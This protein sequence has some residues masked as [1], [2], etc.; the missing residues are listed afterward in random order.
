[1]PTHNPLIRSSATTR[2]RPVQAGPEGP[3]LEP[4]QLLTSP[5]TRLQYRIDR[6]I[7]RGGFGQV[8][9]ARRG[10]HSA[11]VPSTICIKVS[12]HID[13]W[14]REAYFGQILDAH[15][16]AIRVFDTFPLLRPSAARPVL[17][18]PRVRTA[19]RPADLPAPQP[20]GL[21]RGQDAPRDRR[22]P[23]GARQAPPRPDPAPR[24]D[25]AQR[26]RLRPPRAEARRLRHRAAPERP[27]RGHRAHAQP[28]PGAE[29]DHRAHRPEVAGA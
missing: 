22:H 18:G 2:T 27:A 8:Y 19:R 1:M 25:A 12:R 10:G 23:A 13:G 24:P 3:L 17:P 26:L 6:L 15:P 29:R 4:G 9:L 28:A 7:G 5:H 21:A 16:R 11:T 20:R 14:L